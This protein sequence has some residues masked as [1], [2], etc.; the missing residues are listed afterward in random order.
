MTYRR[1]GPK[2]DAAERV[3]ARTAAGVVD[4]V[5]AKKP[6]PDRH[7]RVWARVL[8]WRKGPAVSPEC[9]PGDSGDGPEAA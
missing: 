2:K 7:P 3:G 4:R 1:A 6:K 5:T 9:A 8:A